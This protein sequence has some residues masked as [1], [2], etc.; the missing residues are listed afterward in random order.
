M[1]G[2]KKKKEKKSCGVFLSP[3][4]SLSVVGFSRKQKQK[5]K[6]GKVGEE[7]QE[8]FMMLPTQLLHV[9]V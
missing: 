9:H 8:N 6:V 1:S 2:K 3:S 5:K 7:N 4:L